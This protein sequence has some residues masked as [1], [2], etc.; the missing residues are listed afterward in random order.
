MSFDRWPPQANL[1]REMCVKR[2]IF[3]EHYI[4]KGTVCTFVLNCANFP[5]T[6]DAIAS[7]MWILKT[8]RVLNTMAISDGSIDRDCDIVLH[9]V[10]VLEMW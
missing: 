1:I 7:K 10:H 2:A 8:F 4:N 3:T 9:V 5:P 6:L